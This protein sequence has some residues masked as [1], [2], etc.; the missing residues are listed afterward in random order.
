MQGYFATNCDGWIEVAKERVHSRQIAMGYPRCC[1]HRKGVYLV[2]S[3]VVCTNDS[4]K[5]SSFPGLS[6]PVVLSIDDVCVGC[7]TCLV[8][9]SPSALVAPFFLACDVGFTKKLT[10]KNFSKFKV[11]GDSNSKQQPF[12]W[13]STPYCVLGPEELP[14][15]QLPSNCTVP[16]IRS[17]SSA[18]RCML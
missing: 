7:I 8:I 1:L 13:V 6:T 16:P 5:E 3:S 2:V 15:L 4:S 18:Q 11:V 9:S 14:V 12:L 10:T 17:A